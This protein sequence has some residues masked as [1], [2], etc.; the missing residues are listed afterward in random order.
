MCIGQLQFFIWFYLSKLKQKKHQETPPPP[1]TK[2]T[3]LQKDQDSSVQ[4]LNDKLLG[5]QM[6][7]QGMS[8]KYAYHSIPVLY[9]VAK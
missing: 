7:Q 2:K 9:H 4:K 1:K 3:R 6:S 5:L 8:C